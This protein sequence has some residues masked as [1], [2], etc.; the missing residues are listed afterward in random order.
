MASY[1]EETVDLLR[2]CVDA[3]GVG[4]QG[5]PDAISQ[6][7]RELGHQRPLPLP[8]QGHGEVCGRVSGRWPSF[9]RT[10]RLRPSR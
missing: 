3:A 2:R 6:G 10:V 7:G 1:I 9:T 4:A 8:L 5:R